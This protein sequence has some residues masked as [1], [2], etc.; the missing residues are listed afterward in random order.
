MNEISKEVPI[1]KKFT[2]ILSSVEEIFER[3]VEIMKHYIEKDLIET[4]LSPR[5][6]EERKLRKLLF[7]YTITEQNRHFRELLKFII[8][9]MIEDTSVISTTSRLSIE[10][11]MECPIRSEGLTMIIE[12]IEKC[13]GL[14]IYKECK[15][16]IE[17][18][19]KEGKIFEQE[20]KNLEKG[21]NQ[22]RLKE[23]IAFLKT[24]LDNNILTDK[25]LKYKCQILLKTFRR[26][27]ENEP[28]PRDIFGEVVKDDDDDKNKNIVKFNEH[29]SL[30]YQKKKKEET[31][32]PGTTIILIPK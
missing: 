17:T 21:D 8:N 13:Q 1:R 27:F 6:G 26:R 18:N 5:Y 16:I 20:E 7:E 15:Q 4:Q 12:L 10:Y 11:G 25:F 22:S 32:L 28:P 24:L 2:E 31:I 3:D 29:S 30:Y 9:N 14:A 23:S 19:I